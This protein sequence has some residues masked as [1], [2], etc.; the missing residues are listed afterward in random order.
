M[1]TSVLLIVGVPC[2]GFLWLPTFTC[3]VVTKS[4]TISNIIEI[5]GY[6]IANHNKDIC[7][8]DSRH[9]KIFKKMLEIVAELCFRN[10]YETFDRQT[11]GN[12]WTDNALHI[13]HVKQFQ[14]FVFAR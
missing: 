9:E 10:R 13:E 6:S 12:V 2:S 11:K 3:V 8:K 7:P 1:N 14:I 5:E 4:C